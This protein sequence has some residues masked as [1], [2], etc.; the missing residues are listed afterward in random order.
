MYLVEHIITARS[1]TFEICNG[2]AWRAPDA[3]Q[4]YLDGQA[5]GDAAHNVFT[6][7][8]LH[9]DTE[10]EL[11]VRYAGE[12]CGLRFRT[13]TQRCSIDIRAFGAVGDGVT[14]DTAFIQAAISACPAGGV[15]EFPAG[16]WLSGPLF[17]KSDIDLYL[18][19]DAR[20]VGHPDIARWPVLPGIVSESSDEP[21]AYLGTWEGHPNACHAALLNG[22]GVRNVRIHGDGCIDA[23]ASFLTWWSQP[24]QPF[25]GWRPRT[26]Y[27]VHAERLRVS[28]VKLC[29]SPSWTVHALFCRDVR[30]ADVRIES[31]AGSPNTDGIVPESCEQVLIA[32]A[33]ISTGDDCV[34]I[35]SGKAWIASR[36]R[37][38]TRNVQV[39]NCFMERGH[40]GVV[41]GSE[42]SGGVYDVSIR[43]CVFTGTDRGLR[44]K[45]RRGRGKAA[46]IDGVQLSN[47]TMDRVGTPFVVNS[48]YF[49]DP[50]GREP[51]VGDRR[52]LPVDDGTPTLRNIRVSQVDC[53]NVAHSAGFVLGLPERPLDGL[54]LRDYRVR[55]DADAAPGYPD[56][57][58][59]IQAVARAGL[60]LC[61]I[62]GAALENID[63][64]GSIGPP[65]TRE[66]APE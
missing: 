36:V 8:E 10:H 58:E 18:A 52:A 12:H 22:I 27:F 43:D 61:N 17:L 48:F 15:V 57:A 47:V 16:D 6:L 51:Y 30:I 1:A 7:H 32:G 29:N 35:K 46:I 37:C 62:R 26:V 25:L 56:R 5:V 23:N 13:A 65:I 3:H 34:A 11:T 60:Y 21:Q 54:T 2:Y 14:D 38:A 66:N 53:M 63:I 28:G 64:I 59:S 4:L 24:K 19:R 49:C 40:G 33:H 31:P 42:M 20:L 44:I 9:P 41:I 55:F 50:D 39:S 45:T